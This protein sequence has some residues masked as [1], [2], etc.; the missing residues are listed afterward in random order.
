VNVPD[1]ILLALG[2]AGLL[3]TLV[4]LAQWLAVVLLVGLA[5][6]FAIGVWL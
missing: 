6:G 3:L 5:A 4:L 1:W 2:A